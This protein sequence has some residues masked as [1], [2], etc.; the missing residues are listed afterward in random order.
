M[1]CYASFI[2]SKIDWSKW[3][4]FLPSLW[5][6]LTLVHIVF[7]TRF[8]EIN[9]TTQGKA[10]TVIHHNILFLVGFNQYLWPRYHKLTNKDYPKLFNFNSLYYGLLFIITKW[11][12]KSLLGYIVIVISRFYWKERVSKTLL[13]CDLGMYMYMTP[14]TAKVCTV[15][16]CN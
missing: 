5:Y 8:A 13:W 1:S 15:C 9:W 3:N 4:G 10:I 2:I 6:V 14:V 11:S 7:L 16:N 12:N